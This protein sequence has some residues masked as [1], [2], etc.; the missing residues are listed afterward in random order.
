MRVVIDGAVNLCNGREPMRD[1]LTRVVQ[2][3][4]DSDLAATRRSFETG[5]RSV[6]RRV[7]SAITH[8]GE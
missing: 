7:C 8:L 1:S 4:H 5:V 3:L 6:R 2:A